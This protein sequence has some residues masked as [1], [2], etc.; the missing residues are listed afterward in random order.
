MKRHGNLHDYEK[1]SSN[2]LSFNPSETTRNHF[3]T[4][5]KCCFFLNILASQSPRFINL[6]LSNSFT[7]HTLCLLGAAWLESA[8]FWQQPAVSSCTALYSSVVLLRFS[9][10]QPFSYLYFLGFVLLRKIKWK[11]KSHKQHRGC[12]LPNRL[13]TMKIY[14]FLFC[15]DFSCQRVFISLK[16][17][18]NNKKSIRIHRKKGK[19]FRVNLQTKQKHEAM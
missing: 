10:R 17:T 4:K 15:K 9:F 7:L 19:T 16:R 2:N 3:L 6:L 14:Y 1:T 13:P 8:K 18:R 12:I 5:D 11:N